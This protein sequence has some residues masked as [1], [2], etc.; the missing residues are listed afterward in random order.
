MV[1]LNNVIGMALGLV[2]VIFV[3]A[4]V[5]G[6]SQTTLSESV[7]S[8]LGNETGKGIVDCDPNEEGDSCPSESSVK[9]EFY[10]E[11][12]LI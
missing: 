8:V 9:P 5:F 10:Q 3:I 2:M 11:Q 4:L 12:V 7:D 1:A 6:F